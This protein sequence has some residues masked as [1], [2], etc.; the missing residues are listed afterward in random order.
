MV[1]VE[2]MAERAMPDVVDERGDAQRTLATK[3][4]GEGQAALRK[5]GYRWRANRPALHEAPNRMHEL[6]M[7]RRWITA[8]GRWS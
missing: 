3:A 6:R 8:A 2:E 5:K 1:I 7:L 4:A